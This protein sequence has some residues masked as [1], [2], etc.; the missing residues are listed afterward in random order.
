M[1]DLKPWEVAAKE[2]PTDDLKPWE[3][4]AKTLKKKA[5][6][7]EPASGSVESDYGLPAS[8][9]FPLSG[10]HNKS[11]IPTPIRPEGYQV[12]KY[13]NI[14][15]QKAKEMGAKQAPKT[16]KSDRGILDQVSEA[17]YLP[18]FNKGFS[19]L[20]VKPM[21]GATDI[22]D[23]TIDKLY[24]NLTGEETPSWLKKGGFFDETFKHF[25]EKYNTRDLPTNLASEVA[26]STVGTLPLIASLA[27]GQG[28]ANIL[29]KAPTLF[30][31][32]SNV[33]GGNLTKT[34]AAT[35]GLNAFKDATDAGKDLSESVNEATKGTAEGIKESLTLQAQMLVGGA[36]GKGVANK[37]AKKGLL[38]GGKSTEAILHA[39]SVGTV[40]GG[41]SA[42]SDLMDGKD[43]DTHEAIKQFGVGLAFEAIPVAKTLHSEI[44]ESIK[45]KKIN[46]HAAQQ[47]AMA[48]T[49]SNLNAESAVRNIVSMPK[50]LILEI[51]KNVKESTD[52]LYSKSIEVGAKAY[53]TENNNHKKDLYAEQLAIKAQG[54]I[55][56]VV[57]RL[58]DNKDDIINEIE[59]SEE[60]SEPEKADLLD[61]INSLSEQ[62][63]I[64]SKVEPTEIDPINEEATITG[65]PEGNREGLEGE[66]RV[67]QESPAEEIPQEEPQIT[68]TNVGQSA[69]PIL[70]EQT[71]ENLPPPQEV[72][73]E[74][75][76]PE[77]EVPDLEI[78]NEA[79]PTERE[80]QY[81]D[82]TPEQ[83]ASKYF[84]EVNSPTHL[85]PKEQA[86]ADIPFAIS[87]ESY[88][89]FGDK[90]NISSS[91]AKSYFS[92]TGRGADIIAKEINDTKFNGDEVVEPQDVIDFIDR[93]PN[94]HER[95]NT[96]A[97]NP[98]LAEINKAYFDKTGKKLNKAT[99][100]RYA[101]LALKKNEAEKNINE[102]L[103]SLI[104]DDGITL[105][106]IDTPES[107]G[108]IGFMKSEK[109]SQEEATNLLKE[110]L[111]NENK[112]NG[113]NTKTE[114]IHEGSQSDV[115]SG[116][117][118]SA[119]R[120]ERGNGT[121]DN[122]R[123]GSNED[124]I[125][126]NLLNRLEGD[127]AANESKLNGKELSQHEREDLEKISTLK[128]AKD[129]NLWIEDLYS[130][131]ENTGL[132]GNE[133]TLALDSPNNTIYKSNNLFNAK[134][135][136]S[137]L[138]KQVGFH[139]EVFPASKYDIVGFT[140]IDKGNSK[141][142]HIEVII[143]QSLVKDATNSTPEEI[144]SYMESR[145]FEKVN[146]STFKND[147]YTVSDLHPRNVL[148][149]KNGFLH[150]IDD[151]IIE[152]KVDEKSNDNGDT[153]AFK[154]KT[155]I[156]TTLEEAKNKPVS[157]HDISK[158]IN[159]SFGVPIRK[160]RHRWG[161]AIGIYKVTPE[162]IRVKNT[163]DIG[164]LTHELAHHIDKK[165]FQKKFPHTAELKKLDYDQKKQRAFE[166]FAEFV[167]KWMT[168]DG[169]L[170]KEAPKFLD[171]WENDF[172]KNNK[173]AGTPLK[174]IKQYVDIWKQ[175]G[176]MNRVL[177][178]LDS[179]AENPNAVTEFGAKTRFI[180]DFIDSNHT[181]KELVNKVIELKGTTR[182]A[183]ESDPT[184]KGKDPYELAGVIAKTA[185]SKAAT[186]VLSGPQD[187]AGNTIG[188]SLKEIV[189]PV[190]SEINEALAYVVSLRRLD[191]SKKGVEYTANDLQDAKWIVD[192]YKGNAEFE[193][194]A[195]EVTEFNRRPIEY[196][197]DAGALTPEL[198][199]KIVNSD[200]FYVPLK[201]LTESSD[202]QKPGKSKGLTNTG[203][204]VSRFGDTGG[205]V[206]NPMEAM[207]QNLERMIQVADKS[208]VVHALLDITKDVD[209][210]GKIIEEIPAPLSAKS[211][212]LEALKDQLQKAG[213]DLSS[214]DMDSFI[215]LYS[216]GGKS[217]LPENII[218]LYKEGKL[219][220]YQVDPTL[221]KT[222]AGYENS[223]SQLLNNTWI[224]KAMV[225][226]TKAVRLGAT[227]ARAGF[228]LLSNPFR[229]LFTGIMQT[230][231]RAID[232]PFDN[233]RAL[234]QLVKG[235]KGSDLMRRYKGSGVEMSTPL[236]QDRRDA[237][238]LVN[239]ALSDPK[240]RKLMNIAQHPVEAL[241]KVYDAYIDAIS[242][243]E[244]LPRVAEYRKV[245]EKYEPL[246]EAAK[247]DGDFA[248]VKELEIVRQVDASSAANEVTLNFK[249][250]GIY[251]A[252]INQFAFGF[253][254]AIRGLAKM[255]D[256]MTN[257]PVQTMTR[258]ILSLA[259][260][261]LALYALNK[262]EDWYK[263]LPDWEKHGFF[264]FKIGENIVRLPKP[265]EW[266]W[267]FST[268]PETL[269]QTYEDKEIN[270]IKEG[271]LSGTTVLPGAPIPDVVKPAI[272]TYFNWDLFRDKTIVPKSEENLLPQLQ[273]GKSTTPVAKKLGEIL[274]VSPRKVDFLI[275]GYT[276]GM[277]SELINA[278]GKDYKEAA[279]LP[280]VGRLF[281]RV[282]STVENGQYTQD[283]YEMY[284]QARKITNSKS[285]LR[286]GTKDGDL[287]LTG[288]KKFIE[289][290]AGEILSL[291]KHL[292]A[293]RKKAAR[294][295]QE[296]LPIEI[297][298]K[299]LD[300]VAHAQFL[301]VK[302]LLEKK[303]EFLHQE[304]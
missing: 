170:T 297:K 243:P 90:N 137:N 247:N 57:D 198:A 27:T 74:P 240:Q 227:G 182:Q 210:V 108:L 14:V 151:I 73:P 261:S 63:G 263:N 5:S 253:N 136:I 32:L 78:P 301:I 232:V 7:V 239:D 235:T 30:G 221:Y 51:D 300:S 135:L 61:K 107:Q 45:G 161:Q 58:R 130:L 37:L 162:V 157:V 124:N 102:D 248:K 138:L 285:Q 272:Q 23:R 76:K 241:S 87:K 9:V 299:T 164:T 236:G 228:Q 191:R 41:T 122:E 179:K 1:E 44:T 208:R 216:S 8:Q 177:G 101:E 65:D 279:D 115:G 217:N 268:L 265:F 77:A 276:G 110:T 187:F 262:D 84:D 167:R 153:Q 21:A 26:E 55:K 225:L 33:I 24:T 106:N 15:H 195:K 207:V 64:K 116:S 47:A 144:S 185:S 119:G 93:F 303:K 2:D 249:K 158:F 229:D 250:A 226:S 269:L 149:D 128:F 237:Q 114:S 242:F 271:L 100:K 19:D 66:G 3:V 302:Q 281:T 296:P 91:K 233:V 264:H 68:D 251:S 234:R 260:P 18:A 129:N 72:L 188:K 96:S 204:T 184:W 54:D 255:G 295:E 146:E 282:S 165:N 25:D 189:S 43:I 53:E 17:L 163:N 209:G 22:I 36:L 244:S 199:K 291:A 83:L 246:I 48:S 197:V 231:G 298:E 150:V 88:E 215:T 288:E 200:A 117:L 123:R 212:S 166:G 28:E 111:K 294:V 252:I 121:G 71:V 190:K 175:Q 6:P 289:E 60:L 196:L 127:I 173:D 223:L 238:R 29:S 99:A 186:W 176:A 273:Y 304:N 192:K 155:K 180:N 103:L 126:T 218:P 92:K 141:T 286:K 194:F 213:A 257:K 67:Y 230:Q 49:A 222:L 118:G 70:N 109:L 267:A 75:A 174:Q 104:Q 97:S 62:N 178:T 203:K 256:L 94:G 159:E 147:K 16:S 13:D 171:F 40:F 287:K 148:K 42:G 69:E 139:N 86:I 4:A 113:G 266:G 156:A 219:R 79:M 52:D 292:S 214:A 270:H 280:I 10:N 154:T 142:P 46:D 89:R 39:L 169:D 284:D 34:L 112:P 105:A 220:Y 134:F 81:K 145:G 259:L 11:L 59:Q 20:V 181:L 205:N 172:L 131:G 258:G 293:L 31:K 143:K 98:N 278:G 120:G 224:G 133:N 140:G 211:S 254:P 283:F 125:R 202:V 50:D 201:A 193:T 12:P 245:F 95:V 277:A 35:K 56:L 38:A 274:D 82:A 160:G 85:S 168:G 80:S 132:G 183:Y 206:V 152:N 275:S 290:H